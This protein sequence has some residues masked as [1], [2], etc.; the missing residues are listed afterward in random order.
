MLRI[1]IS[2]ILFCFL[3]SCQRNKE[4]KLSFTG[5]FLLDRGVKTRIKLL[6]IDSIFGNINQYLN[7]SNYIFINSETPFV[8][9][10]SPVYKKFIFNS[11]PKYLKDLKKYNITHLNLANNHSYDQGR[12]GLEETIN[13]IIGNNLIPFGYSPTIN[14]TSKPISI[15]VNHLDINIFSSVILPL[16][17]WFHLDNEITMNNSSIDEL[18]V[19]LNSYKR[20]NDYNIVYLHWGIEYQDSPTMQ[21]RIDARK[22]IDSGADLIIGHHPHVIQ[23]IEVYKDKPVFYSIGNFIFD[24]NYPGLIISIISDKK[25]KIEIMPIDIIDCIPYELNEQESQMLF[26]KI[27]SEKYKENFEIDSN[28]LIYKL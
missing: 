21:Q 3:F 28:K 8:Y 24:Q 22:L 18:C 5:D 10:E 15:K 23:E 6:N 9:K 12:N 14:E 7:T 25:L 27:L 4:I 2:C 16:E 1:I 17:N 20:N 11:N 26:D 19:S 13:N